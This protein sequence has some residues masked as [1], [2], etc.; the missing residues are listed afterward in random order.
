MCAFYMFLSHFGGFLLHTASA[1]L[2]KKVVYLNAIPRINQ[3]QRF[4]KHTLIRIRAR[5]MDFHLLTGLFVSFFLSGVGVKVTTVHCVR[6]CLRHKRNQTNFEPRSRGKLWS[7]QR[8]IF[9]KL[10]T[11]PQ[12]RTHRDG[13]GCC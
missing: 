3:R 9:S 10:T 8:F 5:P 4:C 11:P 7:L 12:T 6:P 13:Q 1:P 2:H